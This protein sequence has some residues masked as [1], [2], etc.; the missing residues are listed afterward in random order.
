MPAVLSR[1]LGVGVPQVLN[2]VPATQITRAKGIPSA[3]IPV[4]HPG[5]RAEFRFLGLHQRGLA[6]LVGSA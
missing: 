6:K 2:S 5:A 3:E 1:D 4:W